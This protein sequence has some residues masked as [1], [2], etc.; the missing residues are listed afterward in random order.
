MYQVKDALDGI[1]GGNEPEGH[2]QRSCPPD[3]VGPVKRDEGFNGKTAKA[4]KGDPANPRLDSGPPA[5]P[6]QRLLRLLPRR[7]PRNRLVQLLDLAAAVNGQYV[8]S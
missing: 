3:P 2:K 6:P 5:P 8:S 1:T 4:D 7:D